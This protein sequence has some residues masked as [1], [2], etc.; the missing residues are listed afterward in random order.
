MKLLNF[1][2]RFGFPI[3]L[4]IFFYA[5]LNLSIKWVIVL[6]V[7]L[8]LFWNVGVSILH[9]LEKMEKEITSS[10]E[11]KEDNDLDNR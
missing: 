10:E 11:K 2:E 1:Y 4:V 9:K 6:A 8:L 3:L 7:L 5:L